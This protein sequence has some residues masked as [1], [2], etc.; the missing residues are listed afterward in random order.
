MG[1]GATCSADFHVAMNFAGVFKVPVVFICQN[2]HWSISVPTQRQTASRVDRDQGA[3]LRLPGREGATATTPRSSTRPSR[4]AVERAR[5]GGGPTLVECETYRIGAH[6]TSDD[7][8][9][10]RDPKEVEVWKK[11][12]PI[13]RLQARV[14]ER[15]AVD[16]GRRRGAAQAELLDEVNRRSRRPRRSP[17]R[18]SRPS[19]RTST[20]SC[21]G[22]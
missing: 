15:E 17:T 10:Y 14:F 12:D 19:S 2:N 1:D 11:R 7:P 16:E 4:E 20:P 5:S 13:E 9:R 6:S 18:R 3:G 22:T 8:T 21:P